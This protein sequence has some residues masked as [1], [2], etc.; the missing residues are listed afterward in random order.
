VIPAEGTHLFIDSLAIPARS[1]NAE[2]A[3]KFMNFVL[4]PEISKEIS[5][6]FPY[7]NPNLAAREL[8]TPEQRNNPAS[9]PTDEQL[10]S[11]QTFEPI[12]Q[13]ASVVDELITTLKVQ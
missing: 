4:R 6:A 1:K 10:R 2:N 7:L 12:G 3:Q 5:E 13:Q 8:L 9:F 11:M